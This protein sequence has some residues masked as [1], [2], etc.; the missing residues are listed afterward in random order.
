MTQNNKLAAVPDASMLSLYRALVG[1]LMDEARS[2]GWQD[3]SERLAAIRR[4]TSLP[5]AAGFGI[6]NAGQARAA[7]T[8]ADAVV[9]GSALVAAA[10]EGRLQAL[11]TELAGALHG[12]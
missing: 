3:V 6:S 1:F 4:S 5:V 9:V 7:A 8:N 12:A 10:R 11:V 2:R